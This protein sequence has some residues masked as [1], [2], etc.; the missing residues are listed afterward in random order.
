[1]KVQSIEAVK[2]PSVQQAPYAFTGFARRAV[3]GRGDC[4]DVRW[5]WPKL[6]GGRVAEDPWAHG[7]DQETVRALCVV[8]DEPRV[9]S[10]FHTERPR[11]E[12]GWRRQ[13]IV[14]VDVGQGG[15]VVACRVSDHNGSV[16]RTQI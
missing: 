13:Y 5:L 14:V 10:L 1:M 7:C 11:V 8:V 15:E 12:G 9:T 6:A 16:H 4:R 2:E 3:H